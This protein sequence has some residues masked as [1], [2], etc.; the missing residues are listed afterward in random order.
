MVGKTVSR[1]PFASCLKVVFFAT[2]PKRLYPDCA[3]GP[4]PPQFRLI[5]EIVLAFQKCLTFTTVVE[6]G[7]LDSSLVNLFI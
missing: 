1:L 6:F 5:N 2:S 4:P 7:I 3:A